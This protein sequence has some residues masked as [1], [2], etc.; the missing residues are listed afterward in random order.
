MKGKKEE[1]IKWWKGEPTTKNT[2]PSKILPSHL[3]EKSSFPDKQKLIQQ[4]QTSYPKN[5]KG[6]SL[7]RKHKW[8]KRPTENKPQTIKKTVTD[9]NI[10]LI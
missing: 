9:H 8:K 2:L 10:T 1:K 4:H 6:T 7:D 3:I 5:A